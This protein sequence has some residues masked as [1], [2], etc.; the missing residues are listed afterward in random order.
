MALQLSS[1][2][3]RLNYE[4]DDNIVEQKRKKAKKTVIEGQQGGSGLLKFFSLKITMKK[5][6]EDV[7]YI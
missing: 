5:Q 1:T 2:E 6:N 7:A 3:R 4:S